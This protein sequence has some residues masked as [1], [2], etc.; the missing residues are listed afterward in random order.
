MIVIVKARHMDLTPSLKEHAEQ[1]LGKALMRIA[2][3]PSMRVEIELTAIGNVRNGK[4][5]ECRVTVTLPRGKPI[6]IV[7]IDDDMYKAID[8]AHDRLLVQVK[9]ERDR[10]QNPSTRRK[11]AS[12]S[13]DE[14]AR[15]NLTTPRETWEDEVQ[16][17]EAAAATARS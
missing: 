4:N 8:L 6:N 3:T 13:R 1:K 9:R 14:T 10:R 15:Q 5:K 16:Q 17:F 11:A 7:E 12:K 2:D